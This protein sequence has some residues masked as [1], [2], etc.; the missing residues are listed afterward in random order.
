V[1]AKVSKDLSQA[2][3]N[4][5]RTH[6]QV[7][8][9]R[10]ESEIVPANQRRLR[11]RAMTRAPATP[12][13]A[14]KP[15]PITGTGTMT[16]ADAGPRVARIASRLNAKVYLSVI[17]FCPLLI[18]ENPTTEEHLSNKEITFSFFEYG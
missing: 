11:Y 14:A 6:T 8:P 2:P 4:R 17:G 9:F 7:V 1:P 10:F 3:N 18:A 13:Y 5:K 12:P 16:A 15:T